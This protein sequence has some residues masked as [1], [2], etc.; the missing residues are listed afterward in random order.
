M[1]E[2]ALWRARLPLVKP[3]KVSRWEFHHFEPFIAE[4]R[5]DDG[6]VGWGEAVITDGYGHET[7]A[8]GWRALERP[9]QRIA[10]LDLAAQ[11]RAPGATLAAAP[12]ATN[13]LYAAVAK[14]AGDPLVA[15]NPGARFPTTRRQA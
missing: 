10:G 13:V 1:E 4:L 8:E 2:S 3:Y 14:T 12:P 7:M 11:R 5:A 15:G 6:R 9:A